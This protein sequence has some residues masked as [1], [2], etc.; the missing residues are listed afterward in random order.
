MPTNTGKEQ[1]H[2]NLTTRGG[3][4]GQR[5]VTTRRACLSHGLS[6]ILPITGRK[7]LASVAGVNTSNR[8]RGKI[9]KKKLLPLAITTILAFATATTG[10]A[11][12]STRVTHFSFT[13]PPHLTCGILGSAVVHGTSVVRDTGNGTYFKSGTWTG[14]FTAANTGNSTT[15]SIAGPT[16]QASPPV[17]DLLAGTVTITTTYGGLAERLSI[18]NGPTLSRDAG[19][20]TVVDVYG[21]TGIPTDPA[22]FD[23]LRSETV[24]GLDGPHPDQLSGFS[25]FC[26]VIVPVL[27]GP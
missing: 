18:T 8:K 23:D 10:L 26:D 2:T 12:G 22:N 4:A 19:S 11:A 24:S 25:I 20:V 14:V 21:Y 5:G 17:I 3:R 16:T 9:M 6:V 27:E 1:M 15:L 7:F 13:T